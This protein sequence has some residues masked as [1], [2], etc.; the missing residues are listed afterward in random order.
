MTVSS[1]PQN[2]PLPLPHHPRHAFNI[3][4][5]HLLSQFLR[6]RLQPRQ[7]IRNLRINKLH[8]AKRRVRVQR[9]K[10]ILHIPISLPERLSQLL[11]NRAFRALPKLYQPCTPASTRLLEDFGRF[12]RATRVSDTDL[13][14]TK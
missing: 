3:Q 14:R 2:L 11:R 6:L 1:L 13:E 10:Q 5:P 4:P 12:I 8:T 9:P 7:P